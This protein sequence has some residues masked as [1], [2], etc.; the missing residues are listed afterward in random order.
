VSARRRVAGW[1]RAPAVHFALIG[2]LLFAVSSALRP[3]PVDAPVERTPIVVSGAQV[4]QLIANFE[5]ST[6][7]RAGPLDARALVERQIDDEVLFRE[8]RAHGLDRDDSGVQWR[9]IEKM[10]FLSDHEAPSGDNLLGEAIGLGLD[11]ED[12]IVRRILVEKMRLALA[13]AGSQQQPTDAELGAYLEAHRDRFM[14]PARVRFSHLLL[15]RD[16]RPTS[17]AQDAAALLATLRRDGV[18]PERATKLGDPF[19]LPTSSW[20]VAERE[21]A[22]RLGPAF[23][24]AVATLEPGSWSEPIASPFG[25]HLVWVH[26]RVPERLPPLA[27]VRGP[28][29]YGLLAER[30]AAA[31]EQGVRRLRSQYT[32][33]VEWPDRL[34]AASPSGSS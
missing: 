20:S 30:R 12:P 14:Q 13:H 8:A 2:A 25:L 19:A 23:A 24:G 29:L 15:S 1:L 28:I 10:T 9:L 26:E 21:L 34:A 16:R 33:Q 31:L 5:R 22:D 11:Q 4:E 27:E 17:L 6:G 32:V 18:P 3:A 7:L